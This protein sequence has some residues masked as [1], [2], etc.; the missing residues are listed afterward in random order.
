MFVMMGF[1]PQAMMGFYAKSD[2]GLYAKSEDGLQPI[3]DDLF[4]MLK[5]L[6]LF[7]VVVYNCRV[8]Q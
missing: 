4:M 1:M 2:D 7:D 8:G 5:L 6:V 3:C